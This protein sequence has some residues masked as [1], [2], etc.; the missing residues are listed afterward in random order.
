MERQHASVACQ[1]LSDESESEGVSKAPKD[2]AAQLLDERE[3][4]GAVPLRE[5]VLQRCSKACYSPCPQRVAIGR[6]GR[7]STVGGMRI[8]AGRRIH[9]DE[10]DSRRLHFFL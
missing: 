6:T 1:K 4:G 3:S 8:L 7:A 2:Q 10:F 9:S 5:S